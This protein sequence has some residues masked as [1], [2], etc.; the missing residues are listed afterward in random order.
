MGLER[1]LS[2]NIDRETAII[3]IHVFT[4]GAIPLIPMILF[5]TSLWLILPFS[6][7]VCWFIILWY[8]IN[9][10]LTY[11]SNRKFEKKLKELEK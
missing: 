1:K 5:S 6:L 4:L 8:Y 10:V 3:I 11:L 9:R 2:I 7:G